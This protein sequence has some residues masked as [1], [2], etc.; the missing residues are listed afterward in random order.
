MAGGAAVDRRTAAASML[1]DM[2]GHRFLA[3]LREK[4]AGVVAL[5][6][7]EGDRPPSRPGSLSTD[8]P[9]LR[10]ISVRHTA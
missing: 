10:A 5:I 1:R 6:G 9:G 2:Q 7:T 8:G 3:Q 4:G